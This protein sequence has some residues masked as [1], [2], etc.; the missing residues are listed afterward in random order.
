MSGDF[1]Q[2]LRSEVFTSPLETVATGLGVANIVLL[3][4]RSIWNYPV[5]IVMVSIYSYVFFGARLYSDALLQIFFFVVQIVGWTAW[6]KHQEPDGEV[7]VET[8][9]TREL[10]AALLLTGVFALALGSAMGRWAHAAFPYYDATV[11][12]AS[13][14][15]QLMLTWRRIENWIWWIGANIISIVIYARKGLFLTSGLYAFFLTMAV[16]GFLSWR[17]SLKAQRRDV[18]GVRMEG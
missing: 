6:L 14:I 18:A 8:C 9:T 1:F 5:G 17:K 15:A 12:A 7:I 2:A 4:R 3:I 13:V 16:L 10:G 11:A